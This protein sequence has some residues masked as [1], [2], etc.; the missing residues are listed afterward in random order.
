M[1]VVLLLVVVLLLF[2]WLVLFFEEV[3]CENKLIVSHDGMFHIYKNHN[4][5]FWT[6]SVEKIHSGCV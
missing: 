6:N 5:L 4:P 2:G 3:V 1:K